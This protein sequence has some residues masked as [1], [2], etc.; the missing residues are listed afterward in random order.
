[1]KF[2]VKSNIQKI[3]A[4]V[5]VIV[6]VLGVLGT[7]DGIVF[8]YDHKTGMVYLSNRSGLLATYEST[9]T[10]SANIS[11]LVYGKPVT[12]IDEVTDASGTKWYQITYFI[13]DG[14]VQKTAYCKAD[15]I[16]LDINASIIATGKIN[17]NTV[18]L[19]SCTGQ[20]KAPELAV[21]NSGAKVEILDEHTDAGTSYYRVHCAIDS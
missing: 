13:K 3:V 10:E 9:S 18:S 2:C 11:N 4:L 20:Y 1:M 5:L 8:A 19:W 14:A 15:A 16:L 21:L 17:A 7:R 12:V 6:T